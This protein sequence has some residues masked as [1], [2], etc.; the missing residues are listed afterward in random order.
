L[1][2]NLQGEILS[3]YLP[4]SSTLVVGLLDPKWGWKEGYTERESKKQKTN[5]GRKN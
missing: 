3:L 4:E 2:P 1:L 5:A